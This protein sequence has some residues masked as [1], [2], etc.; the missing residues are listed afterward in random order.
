MA[1]GSMDRRG[2]EVYS[3]FLKSCLTRARFGPINIVIVK[4]R[5]KSLVL[6]FMCEDDYETNSKL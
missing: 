1:H 3:V 2:S 5:R 4:F 6:Y